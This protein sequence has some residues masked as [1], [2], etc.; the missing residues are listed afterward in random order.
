M[1]A[2]GGAV[3]FVFPGQGSQYVG[4]GQAWAESFSTAR[5]AFAEA[6]SI[7]GMALSELC[8]QGPEEELQLTANTQPAILAT[9]VAIQRVVAEHDL[10]PVVVA[11][12]SLGEYSALVTAGCLSFADALRLVRRRG[13]LMQE[14]VPVGVGA[15]AAIMGLEAEAVAAIAAAAKEDQIC[16][17]ANYNAPNQTVVA[18][19]LQAVERAVEAAEAGGAMRA[20]MLPVSAPFHSALMR[21]A[22][23]GLAPE[24]EAASFAAPQLPVVTNIDAEPVTTGEAAREALVRQIDG[25][26]RWVESIRWMVEKGGVGTFLEVGP[27]AVLSGLIRRITPGVVAKSFSEPKGLEKYLDGSGAGS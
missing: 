9:S 10:A 17:V 2:A 18:G 27:R 21:P 15:M 16:D 24:L 26:V 14:A 6:D 23:D 1:V 7:L 3:G 13:E 8:W 4:M 22:R 25:P 5:E 20:V 11:G 19:H 12:H